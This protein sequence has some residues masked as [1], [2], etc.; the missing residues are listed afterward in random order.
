M[1][2]ALTKPTRSQKQHANDPFFVPIPHP[3]KTGYALT[4]LQKFGAGFFFAALAMVRGDKESLYDTVSS[5]SHHTTLNHIRHPIYFPQIGAI[6]AA[7]HPPNTRHYI[8][9]HIHHPIPSIP[10]TKQVV[11]GA[12][13]AYRKA[14]AP[15]PASFPTDPTDAAGIAYLRA[16]VSA[17][18]NLDDYDPFQY[19]AWWAAT[20]Q[21]SGGSSDPAPANCRQ[22]GPPL[23]DG[24]GL[25]LAS[26]E[27]DDVPLVRASVPLG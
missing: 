23:P 18:R 26:I 5:V 19:Q 14:H 16:H 10:P 7:S 21:Q 4:Q 11:A 22:V 8:S 3:F 20:Q 6:T 25:P 2:S 27:C 17:C 12:V 13:E 24:S 15:P 1:P 9:P